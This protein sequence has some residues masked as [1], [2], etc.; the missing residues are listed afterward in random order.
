MLYSYESPRRPLYSQLPLTEMQ[1]SLAD[2]TWSRAVVPSLRATA[3]Y[4][5]GTACRR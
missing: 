4:A 5:S 3:F 2:G 1:V